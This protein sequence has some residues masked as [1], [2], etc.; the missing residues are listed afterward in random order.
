MRLEGG[1][2]YEMR[3]SKRAASYF[4]RLDRKTKERIAAALDIMAVDPFS[5]TL[6]IKPIVGR[7]EEFR[8]R[9]GESIG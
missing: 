9:V 3:F 1:K 6:D 4:K 5:N 7:P 8:L 2:I